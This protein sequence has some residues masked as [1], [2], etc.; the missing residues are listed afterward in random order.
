LVLVERSQVIE[1]ICDLGMVGTERFLA[2]RQRTLCQRYGFGG[3]T[4]SV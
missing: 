3:F 2:D 1:R 4:G